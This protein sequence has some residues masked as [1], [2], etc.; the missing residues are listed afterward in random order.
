MKEIVE[1]ESIA[2]QAWSEAEKLK[3]KRKQA[4]DKVKKLQEKGIKRKPTWG[5]R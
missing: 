4:L 2:N 1:L 3:L 5:K